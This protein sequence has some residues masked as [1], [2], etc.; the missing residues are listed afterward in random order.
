M[1]CEYVELMKQ[2]IGEL[3]VGSNLWGMRGRQCRRMKSCSWIT[4]R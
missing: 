4:T 3:H 2:Q 1:Y